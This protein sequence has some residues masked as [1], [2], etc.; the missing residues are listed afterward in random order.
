MILYDL[1][2]YKSSIRVYNYALCVNVGLTSSVIFSNLI[3][4]DKLFTDNRD[5][6]GYF[7]TTY[8][9]ITKH[10]GLT[11]NEIRGAMKKLKECELIF[12]IKKGMP[13]IN[14]YKL[15]N[16]PLIIEKYLK[17]NENNTQS[18]EIREQQLTNSHKQLGIPHKQLTNVYTSNKQYNK[19]E[20]INIKTIQEPTVPCVSPIINTNKLF[21]IEVLKS[22]TSCSKNETLNIIVKNVIEHYNMRLGKNMKD[23]PDNV[24]YIVILLDKMKRDE[25]VNI[26]IT[27]VEINK[28]IDWKIYDW[29]KQYNPKS[30]WN[31]LKYLNGFSTLLRPS[32]FK[33]YLGEIPDNFE[34]P[35][36][37]TPEHLKYLKNAGKSRDGLYVEHN[38]KEADK[39]NDKNINKY[40]H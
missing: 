3:Y 25:E 15:N 21:D 29:Y 30:D 5:E 2:D 7:Y 40:M 19:N 13:S 10:T 34:Y 14:W 18:E 11:V 8:P 32:L 38:Q 28:I 17:I 37:W 12:I 4:L 27:D 22:K 35:K 39:V 36:D 16:N 33:K 1:L 31:G 9:Q 6:E 23:G 26:A 24:K 20:I